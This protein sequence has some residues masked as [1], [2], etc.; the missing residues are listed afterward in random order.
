MDDDSHKNSGGHGAMLIFS[1]GMSP[2]F[3]SGSDAS[4]RLNVSA[5]ESNN[6]TASI[7]RAAVVPGSVRV[8]SF[9]PDLVNNGNGCG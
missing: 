7:E 1:L 5:K 4:Q 9:P 3:Q 8:L 2:A 6:G